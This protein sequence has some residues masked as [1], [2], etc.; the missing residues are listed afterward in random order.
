MTG[1]DLIVKMKELRPRTPMVLISGNPNPRGYASRT[2]A[3][4]FV[5][6]P[7]DR[8]YFI[9]T[10]RRAIRYSRLTKKISK[11]TLR[12]DRHLEQVAE[13][14]RHMEEQATVARQHGGRS[15]PSVEAIDKP[16]AS[17]RPLPAVQ[18]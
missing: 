3:F 8:D 5:Q 1:I 7:I 10:L 12:V 16:V 13:L 17:E 2:R 9:E 6:K 15:V 14:R 4:G 11:A 18:R